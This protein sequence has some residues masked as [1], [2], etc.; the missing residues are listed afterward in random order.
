VAHLHQ[1]MLVEL[2]RRNHAPNTVRSRA[3]AQKISPGT[4]G[5]R[6]IAS[7]QIMSDSMR[8]ISYETESFQR[9]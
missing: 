4:P 2:Q 3:H 9:E 6:H 5:A 7:G 8:L 1:M